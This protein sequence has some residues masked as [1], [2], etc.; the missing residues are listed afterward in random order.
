MRLMPKRGQII[1]DDYLR[2]IVTGELAEGQLLPTET[3]MIEQYS[4][5]RTAVREA[6]QTLAHKG[7]VAIRQ[8]SGSTVAPRTRWN[9]LDSDYLS[10]TG[11]DHVLPENITQ[12]REILEPATARLAAQHA[13][14]EQTARL[15]QLT[16]DFATARPD[17]HQALSA[18]DEAFHREL[19]EAA[20]NPVL[21]SLNA[22]VAQLHAGNNT[23]RQWTDQ[24]I[25]DTKFWHRQIADAIANHDADAAHDAVR[26]HLRQPSSKAV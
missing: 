16:D 17:D 26:M 25:T 5:S 2:R 7:F 11:A 19:S 10:I 18:L 22:S 3:A 4:V 23:P 12:A 1:V 6:V 21:L 20:A 24:A 14:P 9:V 13:T 8:G 15:Q